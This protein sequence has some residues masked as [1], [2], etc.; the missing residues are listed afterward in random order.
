MVP[1]T[2]IC[3]TFVVTL[4]LVVVSHKNPGRS[5][6]SLRLQHDDSILNRQK[7]NC[8]GPVLEPSERE[9]PWNKRFSQKLDK[10]VA[11]KDADKVQHPLLTALVIQQPALY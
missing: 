2:A 9:E 6:S 4:M 3:S 5:D 1:L 7:P 10:E 8:S 11:S